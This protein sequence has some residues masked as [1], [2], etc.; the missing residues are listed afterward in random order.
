MRAFKGP[1]HQGG[2]VVLAGAVIGV[3]GSISKQKGEDKANKLKYADQRD[4]DTLNFEQADWLKQQERVWELQDYQT[5]QN[6]KENAI[7]GFRQ[8][9]PANAADPNGEWQEPPPL[10]DVSA[11]TEGLAQ[12][13]ENGQPYIIDPRTGQPV[14]NAP[15]K[16]GTLSQIAA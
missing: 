5:A 7:G 3:A 16:P 15:K 6:Y 1:K 4:L 12:R 14:F 10:T 9:A 2:W 11:Q 8:Y 13:D